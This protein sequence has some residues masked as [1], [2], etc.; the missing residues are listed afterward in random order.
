MTRKRDRLEDIPAMADEIADLIATRF[1]GARRTGHAP[2]HLMLRRRGAALPA[3]LRARAARLA[4]A[5]RLA[6]QPKIARQMPLARLARD[7]AALRA[8]LRPLG[9]ATR[10]QGRAVRIAAQVAL[11]LLIVAALSVWLAVRRGW[12]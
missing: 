10:W 3:R 4:E 8:H 6:A 9:E 2:L 12:L 1:G 7:H 11:G 5:D